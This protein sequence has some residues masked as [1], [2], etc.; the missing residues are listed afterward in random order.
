MLS[1]EHT[2]GRQQGGGEDKQLGGDLAGYQAQ[3]QE[4]H[5]E[6]HADQRQCPK[7]VDGIDILQGQ[8]KS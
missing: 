8:Y 6:R 7:L 5:T 4:Q 2:Y 1:V 3:F